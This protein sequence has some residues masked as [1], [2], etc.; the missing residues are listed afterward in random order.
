[1]AHKRDTFPSYRLHFVAAA[2]ARRNR[3]SAARKGQTYRDHVPWSRR[4]RA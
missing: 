1:M 2:G 3:G 4:S